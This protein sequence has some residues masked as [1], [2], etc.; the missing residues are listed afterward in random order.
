MVELAARGGIVRDRLIGDRWKSAGAL[1][2]HVQRLVSG[3]PAGG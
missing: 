1:A 2:P 3:A